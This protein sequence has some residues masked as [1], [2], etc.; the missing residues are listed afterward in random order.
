MF[1]MSTFLDYYTAAVPFVELYE[2][3]RGKTRKKCVKFFSKIE[4]GG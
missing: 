2:K 3:L 1:L 4:K